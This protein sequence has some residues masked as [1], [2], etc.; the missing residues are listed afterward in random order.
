MSLETLLLLP[1]KRI[2][3]AEMWEEKCHD[4]P[5]NRVDLTRERC[6]NVKTNQR[7]IMPDPMTVKEESRLAVRTDKTVEVGKKYIDKNCDREGKPLRGGFAPDLERG[8]KKIKTRIKNGE[9][10]V[11]PTDKSKR[12]V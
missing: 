3:V 5:R 8:I 1:I 9:V 11:R 12:D 4:E 2:E 6:T 10:I 7:V